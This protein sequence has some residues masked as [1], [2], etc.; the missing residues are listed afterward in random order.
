MQIDA[1]LNSGNSGGL[2]VD[3]EGNLIARKLRRMCD[4]K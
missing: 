4:Q 2:V 1:A 3:E